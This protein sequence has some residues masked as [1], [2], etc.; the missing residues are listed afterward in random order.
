M[1]KLQ[2]KWIKCPTIDG[3]FIRIDAEHPVDIYVGKDNR[4]FYQM[5]IVTEHKKVHV[6]ESNL[7]YLNQG[8]RKDGKRIALLVLSSLVNLQPYQQTC[9]ALI[10]ALKNFKD[11]PNE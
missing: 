10:E 1:N 6:P 11:A 5:L 8:I 9:F 4:G 3:T 7:Y 2:E